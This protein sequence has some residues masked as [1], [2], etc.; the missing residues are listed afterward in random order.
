MRVAIAQISPVLL[1]RSF[2]KINIITNTTIAAVTPLWA[3]MESDGNLSK[4][5][6]GYD[7]DATRA[8]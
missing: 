3:L 4:Q 7:H 5:L 8:E 6:F 1:G 2:A